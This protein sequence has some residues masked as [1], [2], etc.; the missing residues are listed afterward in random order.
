MAARKR[1]IEL[2][3]KE[4]WEKTSLGKLLKWTLTVGRY[5]VIATELIVILAFLS[6]FKLDRDLTN[7]YEEIKQ[8][9]ARIEA[10]SEFEEEF[11]FLQKRL[12]TIED[13]EKKQLTTAGLI[14]ELSSLIPLDVA[15]TD[16]TVSD[17]KVSLTATALSEQ[18]LATFLNNLKA[19]DKFEKIE[20]SQVVSGIEK[21]VGIQFELKT[22]FQ[23][24]VEAEKE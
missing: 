15:L 6:R 20:L 5:I 23:P 14:E 18:G 7:L 3:P 16:L 9:Q 4:E 12:D 8:K 22:E 11:R 1:D 13:L 2:L 21:G 19:S 10:A 24:A 17:Q